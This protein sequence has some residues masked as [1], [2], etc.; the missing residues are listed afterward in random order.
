MKPC[1]II[2]SNIPFIKGVLDHVAE[3]R[4]LNGSD[5][6]AESVKHADAL[7]IRTRTRCNEALLKGSS[8]KYIATATIGFDHIDTDYCRQHNIAWTNAPGC[9]AGSVQQ[10]I[11]AALCYLHGQGTI[12]LPAAT[13]GI[14]GM[15]HVGKLVASFCESIGVKVLL[16]DPPRQR[17]EK[18]N[19]FV[20]LQNIMK[21]CDIITFHT[22]LNKNGEDKTLHLANDRFFAS[23]QQKPIIINA[24]RGEICD[25]QALKKAHKKEL[26]SGIILDCWEQEPNIDME[27]L[28]ICD[29]ATPHIAGYS[30]DGKANATT[31]CVQYISRC[32]NL[33]LNNWQ[34]QNIPC[35]E[36]TFIDSQ[37]KNNL[38]PFDE[39]VN[40]I[41][42][43]YHIETDSAKLK[44]TPQQFEFFRNNYP[45]RR[46][47]SSYTINKGKWDE[48]VLKQFK[49]LG[50]QIVDGLENIRN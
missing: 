28:N 34:V 41:L 2:D 44:N 43:T 50:F 12:N 7:I 14:V 38:N 18:G 36:N 23:L 46:E 48:E 16:N 30:A 45:L 25:T 37:K 21:Q 32:F 4:Y 15:G 49:T 10:Y 5:I 22:P 47:F 20:S 1:I 9:N 19:D 17:A 6:S 13:V 3:V 39:L 29:I 24:A 33:G 27:L 11:A 26:I 31:A 35:P 8:V 42:Y 40:A